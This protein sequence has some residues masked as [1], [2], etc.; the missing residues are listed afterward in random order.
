MRKR[1]GRCTV[2][3]AEVRAQYTQ[4]MACFRTTAESAHATV[5]KNGTHY[6]KTRGDITKAAERD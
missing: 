1:L 4:G 3:C 2:S 5:S 6:K